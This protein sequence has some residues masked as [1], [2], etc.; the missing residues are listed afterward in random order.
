MGDI[1]YFTGADRFSVA[2]MIDVTDSTFRRM[3]RALCKECMLYTEMIAA[4]A[5]YHGRDFLI[6]YKDEEQPCTLQ[7]GGSDPKKLAVAAKMGFERGYSAIN[8]NAGCPSDKVQSGNFGAVLMKTPEVIASCFKAMQES[9][10]IPVTVKTRIGVDDEDSFEFTCRLI[11]TIYEAGCR[12]IIVHARK[13]W[14]NGLSPK[15]NRSIPPLDYGRV[16]AMKQRHSDLRITIN[17]GI[18]TL[19]ECQEHLKHVD[20]VM[21]GRAI[22]DNPYLLCSVDSTLYGHKDEIKSREQVLYEMAYMADALVSEGIALHH[23]A[24]HL[25]GLFNGINGARAYR[26]YLSEHITKKGADG[27]VLREAFLKINNV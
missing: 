2:P 27:N 23:F 11:D 22:I 4:D 24:R 6:D 7:L 26:R 12:H 13:A 17:G 25:L 5:L 16:Y 8:L 9:V 1:N 18:L 19:D 15:E 3:A 14:L 10:N 21:L 20:G